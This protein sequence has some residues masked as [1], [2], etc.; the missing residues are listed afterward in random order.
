MTND[1]DKTSSLQRFIDA[2]SRVYE[3]VVSELKNGRKSSHW[4]WFIFPQIIG[5]GRSSTAIFYSLQSR[6]EVL[7]YSRHEILGKR[8]RECVGLVLNIT[9]RSAYDIFGSPD[10]MK[11]R[12]SMTLFATVNTIEPIY[13]QALDQYFQGEADALTL[14]ILADMCG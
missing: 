14:D 2:Q 7:D 8:L 3:Q 1:M 9:N 13:Q 11:F 5:L 12:S 4:M 6:Q 10:D